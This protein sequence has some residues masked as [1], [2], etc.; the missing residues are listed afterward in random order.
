[1]V[2]AQTLLAVDAGSIRAVDM[3][4]GKLRWTYEASEP[5]Y[6]VAGDDAVFLLEG[7]VRRGESVS[8][9]CLD[10][11]TGNVRWKKTERTVAAPGP[12]HRVQSRAAG[13]RSLDD[14]RR[15]GRQ[16]H[17]RLVRRRRT[18]VVEPRVRARA[19]AHEAGSGHVRRRIA[20][21]PGAPEVRRARSAD[22]RS[23]TQL[24][25]RILPLLPARGD[26]QILLGRRDGFDR[27]GHRANTTRIGSAKQLAAGTPAG[28]RP[29]G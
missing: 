3:E 7:A 4:S 11:S 19:A 26:L 1:M 8:A 27:S 13:V 23:Q 12:P 29:T 18:G 2:A 17:P 9:T 28:C 15:Q 24:E 14:E 10:L 21:D 6:V 20:L 5:R 25:G 16:R 22:R